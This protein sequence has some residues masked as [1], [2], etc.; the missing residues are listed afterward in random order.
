[1]LNQ[2]HTLIHLPPNMFHYQL[3]GAGEW[4]DGKK[5]TKLIHESLVSLVYMDIY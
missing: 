3:P 5:K 1:M 2:S 4:A